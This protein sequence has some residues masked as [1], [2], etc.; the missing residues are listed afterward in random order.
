M[1]IG[2]T[3]SYSVMAAAVS[4]KES[5]Q[6]FLDEKPA[7]FDIYD[8]T[9]TTRMQAAVDRFDIKRSSTYDHYGN[10]D[11]LVNLSDFLGGIGMNTPADVEIMGEI[12]R[13]I[14][15]KI[16]AAYSKDS[17]WVTVRVSTPNKLF[18][19]PRWHVDGLFFLEHDPK[20]PQSK[21]I[22]TIKGPGTL[23]ADVSEELRGE[24]TAVRMVVGDDAKAFD[25]RAARNKVIS[26]S[27]ETEK[28]LSQLHNSKGVIILVG[29]PT[30]AA[31]HSE[32]SIDAPRIFLS[33]LPGDSADVSGLQKRFAKP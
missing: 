29:N 15:K 12:V 17:A 18:G 19:E 4:L 24:F 20:I 8:V 33:V 3:F 6:K 13:G 5:I 16:C 2:I 31:I 21:F 14:T 1:P 32:P 9:L 26:A 27:A 11:D 22:F 10:A 25:L 28:K 7:P 23:L 30:D